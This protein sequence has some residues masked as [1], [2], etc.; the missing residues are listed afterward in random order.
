METGA[1]NDP[2][3][4]SFGCT[5]NLAQSKNNQQESSK[6]RIVNVPKSEEMKNQTLRLV[7]EQ[8]NIVRRVIGFC[9]DVVKSKRKPGHKVEPLR[10]IVHGG[11]GKKIA[12]I[13][14]LKRI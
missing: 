10:L 1:E 2:Q 13:F 12:L 7:P 8:M 11:A 14:F 4:E 9:K 6:Y 5:D 3:F